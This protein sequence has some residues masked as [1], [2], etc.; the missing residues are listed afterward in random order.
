MKFILAVIVTSILIVAT[1]ALTGC[2]D[3]GSDSASGST[4]DMEV[5]QRIEAGR[6]G[7]FR[8]G[9]SYPYMHEL[10]VHWQRAHPGPFVWGSIE[11]EK[12]AYDWSEADAFVAD[13]QAHQVLIDATI[14]PYAGW[15][16]EQCHEKLPGAPLRFLPTLGD[17][18]G[19]P[20]EMEA[21]ED[22]IRALVERYDG[23]GEDDMPGL[24][25]PV[26][27]W[28][29]SNEPELV[30]DTPFFTGEERVKDYRELLVATAGAIRDSDPGASVLTGG[31][32]TLEDGA[33][34]FWESVLG[35]GEGSL[36][37][38]F[39][40]HAVLATP[41][42]NM[43]A[44]NQLMDGLGLSQP[45]WITEIRIAQG[46]GIGGHEERRGGG[47][48]IVKFTPEEIAAQESWSAEIVRQF[49]SGF[50]AGADKLFYMGLDNATPTAE[51]ARLVNCGVV[52]GGE[53][54]EDHLEMS[55]CVKQKPFFAYKT[56]VDKV[57]Y[58]DSVEKIAPGQ[59]LFM[60]NG[61]SVYVLW[62]G[63]TLPETITGVVTMTDIY[64]ESSQVDASNIILTG[65]PVYIE[66]V[67]SDA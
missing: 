29:V 47:T 3:G 55:E 7:F 42:H 33:A 39:T 11:P 62:G 66:S 63:G 50:G 41:E 8:G 34:G 9:G 14:W 60:V 25:F 18:R 56:M 67:A 48:D 1:L 35:G 65:T 17:Y 13:S 49:I 57:D 27:Y 28:E 26:K 36:I 5:F 40:L 59:Y 21:Y 31:I 30:T 51:G 15:D 38:V 58:F 24:V 54:E 2:G 23:D 52:I 37:D 64:G 53:L 45:V 61:K 22:F 12:G 32:A 6:F 19:R 44:L 20:C 43:A 46:Q 16:Q 4:V 10:G